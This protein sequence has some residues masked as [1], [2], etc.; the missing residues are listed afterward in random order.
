[1]SYVI[2]APETMAAAATNLTS[3]GSELRAAHVAAAPPTVALVPAAADEVS[4][5]VAHLFS[6]YAENFHGLAGR[7]AVFHE[8][9][10]GHLSAGAGSYAAT[11]AAN[12]ASLLH[13]LFH[14]AV[15]DWL[16]SQFGSPTSSTSSPIWSWRS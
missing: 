5:G 2:A 4:A 3:I 8:Q 12:A 16:Y 9:F 14:G 13:P 1:M 15:L 10:V 11:E 7:A 6:R